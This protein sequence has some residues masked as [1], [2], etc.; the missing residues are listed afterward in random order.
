MSPASTT[1]SR[2][3]AARHVLC[4]GSLLIILQ[5]VEVISRQEQ[6]ALISYRFTSCD[7]AHVCDLLWCKMA[8]SMS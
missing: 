8:G 1:S 3:E 5:R 2:G 6:G 4:A 7:L